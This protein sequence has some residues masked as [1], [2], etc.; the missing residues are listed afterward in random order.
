MGTGTA[1]SRSSCAFRG[2][3]RS[4]GSPLV[5]MR[6]PGCCFRGVLVETPPTP[7]MERQPLGE[8]LLA[9]PIDRAI[10]FE[11]LV[12]RTGEFLDS[13]PPMRPAA[14]DLGHRRYAEQPLVPGAAQMRER[15]RRRRVR[16]PTPRRDAR[17]AAAPL[18]RRAPPRQDR[19]PVVAAV[20]QR[21]RALVRDRRLQRC[22]PAR[23]AA[24]R[25]GGAT[26]APQ[27]PDG[28]GGPAHRELWLRDPDGYLVVLAGPDGESPWPD[29]RVG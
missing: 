13:A 12:R 26:A 22:G 10:T 4:T 5:S 6:P 7:E 14:S 11:E 18:R 15:A 25:P 2:R 29:P 9:R 1:S 20:R 16:T 17:A 3:P 8:L 28:P 19:R 23:R 24:S 27:S 21:R